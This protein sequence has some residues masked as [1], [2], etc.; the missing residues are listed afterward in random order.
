MLADFL[1]GEDVSLSGLKFK[2]DFQSHLQCSVPKWVWWSQVK[3][4]TE[5]SC[6]RIPQIIFCFL[7][8]AF[9]LSVKNVCFVQYV[10]EQF[11]MI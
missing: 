5:F 8:F 9:V 1:H 7:Y 4:G 11:V 10:N 6:K 3:Y 2:V